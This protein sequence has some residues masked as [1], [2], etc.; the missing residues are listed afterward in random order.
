MAERNPVLAAGQRTD[1]PEPRRPP[2]EETLWLDYATGRGVDDD[3]RTIE[4]VIG[5][6]RKNPKLVDLLETARHQHARRLMLS[7]AVPTLPGEWLLPG[8]PRSRLRS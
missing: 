4:P 2:D 6:R 7:G 8:C 3:G 5:G 1:R